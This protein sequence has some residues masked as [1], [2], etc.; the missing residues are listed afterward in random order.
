MRRETKKKKKL[1]YSFDTVELAGEVVIAGTDEAVARQLP[2][3]AGKSTM[4]PDS[5]PD[6]SVKRITE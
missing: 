5:K 1:F 4:R 2:R 6:T 3:S